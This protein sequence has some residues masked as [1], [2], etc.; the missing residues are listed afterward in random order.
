MLES[1]RRNLNSV[2]VVQVL[3]DDLAVLEFLQ[4]KPKDI[5]QK[6]KLYPIGARHFAKQA[7]VV[8]NLLGLVNSAAYADESVV[9]HIS[10]I[11]IA[12]I[13]EEAL[14]LDKLD[15]VEENIRVAETKETQA[16]AAQAQEDN[17][18]EIMNRP[19]DVPVDEDGQPLV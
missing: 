18:M 4:I 6:G 11:K 3:D 13:M 9:A 12:R 1:A 7:Q 19:E 10:G 5:N 14:G 8:Q 15:L 16:L 2:E 17:A